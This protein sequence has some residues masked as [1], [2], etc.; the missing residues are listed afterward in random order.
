MRKSKQV[1]ENEQGFAAI[2]IAIVLVTVL[3]LTT[4]GFVQLMRHEERQ[5]LDKQLSSQAYFAAEAGVNDATKAI[6]AGFIG[7]KPECGE[8]VSDP[9]NNPGSQYLDDNTVGVD[10]D[11]T[12]A[13]YPCLLINPRPTSL[14]FDPIG[15]GGSPTVFQM[16]TYN[17]AGDAVVL[18]TIQIS[19]EEPSGGTSFSSGP[20]KCRNLY[21]LSGS[22]T[23]WT[24]TTMLRAEIIPV[25]ANPVLLNRNALANNRAVAFLCPSQGNGTPG[26]TT[27]VNASSENGGVIIEGNCNESASPRK[28]NAVIRGLDVF[29]QPSA[30]VNLRALHGNARV[31]VTAYGGDGAVNPSNQL[32]IARAQTLV[33]ST[34]K[35][36]DV[37]RRI[38]VRVPSYNSYDVPGG[39]TASNKI[40]KQLYLLP[41]DGNS[42]SACAL[43]N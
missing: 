10:G 12:G 38:Q 40:C 13:S 4:V 24:Y 15:V 2:I 32:A 5:A 22:S 41:D 27:Y 30:F 17:S 43:P 11:S 1:G 34:G 3:G 26:S 42:S 35:A 39:T 23:N 8:L 14:E 37:L 21:P 19:W 31:T 7:A 6:N 9:A 18:K 33:D 36:H 25:A 20:D 16:E 29:G 28:C